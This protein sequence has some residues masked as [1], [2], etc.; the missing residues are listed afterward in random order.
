M[1][2]L[3]LPTLVLPPYLLLL[4]CKNPD[5]LLGSNFKSRPKMCAILNGFISKIPRQLGIRI[6][7]TLFL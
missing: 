5:F 7:V 6:I 2:P 3:D 1:L 4:M